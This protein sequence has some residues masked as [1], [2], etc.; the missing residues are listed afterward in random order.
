MV[1][2]TLDRYIKSQMG[3]TDTLEDRKTDRHSEGHIST[4][5][6]QNT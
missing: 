5:D 4:S 1:L 6:G 2:F 3:K